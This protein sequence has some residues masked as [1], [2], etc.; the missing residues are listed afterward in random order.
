M[1]AHNIPERKIQYTKKYFSNRREKILNSI[2]IAHLYKDTHSHS[3]DWNGT[4]KLGIRSK[5][6]RSR[7]KKSGNRKTHHSPSY[8]HAYILHSHTHAP[9]TTNSKF[10]LRIIDNKYKKCAFHSALVVSFSVWFIASCSLL[11]PFNISVEMDVVYAGVCEWVL[12]WHIHARALAVSSN[13]DDD[14]SKG[15]SMKRKKNLL[16]I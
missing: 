9:S 10:M 8:V 7:T 4:W 6:R 11:S 2:N 5:L 12:E 15:K 1:T 3:F 16:F 14:F 13:T